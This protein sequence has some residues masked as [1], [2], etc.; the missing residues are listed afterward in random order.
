LIA[1]FENRK[2][3]PDKKQSRVIATRLDTRM[4]LICVMP[5]TK[6]V[7][8]VVGR[9]AEERILGERFVLPELGGDGEVVQLEK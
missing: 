4:R 3:T 2:A 6:R 8:D 1:N 5:I 7:A 9:N